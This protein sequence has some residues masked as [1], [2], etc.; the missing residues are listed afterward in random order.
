MKKTN[1]YKFL[2]TLSAIF[3]LGFSVS[4]GFDAYNYNTYIGSTP[5]YAYAIIRAVE[6]ILPSIIVLIVGIILKRK[7]K[8]DK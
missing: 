5:L 7:L 3:V 8:T 4:F 1:I 6:F 2:Y